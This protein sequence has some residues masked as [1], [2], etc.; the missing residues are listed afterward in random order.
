M[1]SWE[2]CEY[3]KAL[4]KLKILSFNKNIS[5]KKKKKRRVLGCTGHFL[6]CCCYCILNFVYVFLAAL[7]LH[8]RVGV[9]QSRQVGPA[10]QLCCA[11]FA[12][13]WLLL[14]QSMG[15]G[16]VGF[17]KLQFMDSRAW[18]EQL[19]CT[20]LVAPWHVGSSWTKGQICVPCTGRQILTTWTTSRVP[21]TAIFQVKQQLFLIESLP[22]DRSV[23]E[24]FILYQSHSQKQLLSS[25]FHIT[26][27]KQQTG[28]PIQ[29]LPV[30]H[31]A[32]SSV[33][34]TAMGRH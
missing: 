32:M 31:S 5:S 27:M 29:L 11:G 6:Y 1:K 13:Q 19:W 17:R 8:C 21:T 26:A 14:L 33:S 30:C 7:G 34:V 24:V 10:L 12:L 2:T 20:S 28:I 15:S 18:A 3:C 4:Q 25:S 23:P 16:C 9:L 22:C